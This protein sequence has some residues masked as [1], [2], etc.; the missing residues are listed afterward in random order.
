MSLDVYFGR[1][2]P[3]SP[4]EIVAY[5]RDQPHIAIQQEDGVTQ[6]LY[7]NPATGVYF[8]FDV[9]DPFA[10]EEDEELAPSMPLVLSLALNFNR[11][12]FFALE[13]F[14]LVGRVCDALDLRFLLEPD[15]P[16]RAFDR[17]ALIGAWEEGNRFAVQ[18]I[19]EQHEAPPYME[20][21]KADEWWRYAQRK[22]ELEARFER[23]GYD[24]FVPSLMLMHDRDT[25]TVLRTVAW[26]EAIPI[27]MPPADA[28]FVRRKT[29]KR[30]FGRVENGVVDAA[31][32]LDAIGPHARALEDAL[33]ILPPEE[34]AS[35]AVRDAFAA[36][37]LRPLDRARYEG[38]APDGFV[39]VRAEAA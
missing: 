17:D 22:P 29:G 35:D 12:T 37:P 13:C 19:T 36:L 3:P 38:V 25:N 18:V 34:A 1:E 24:A 7:Q 31:T 20:R 6:A 2:S 30:L 5:L 16:P 32:V 27:V 14:D 15:K 10:E 23:D 28:F 39:D 4:P 21:E 9:G 26:P 33:R 8:I 11:P